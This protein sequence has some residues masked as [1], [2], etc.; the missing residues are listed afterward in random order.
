MG[1]AQAPQLMTVIIIR[2]TPHV[3]ETV[4]AIGPLT[5]VIH[6][7]VLISLHGIYVKIMEVVIGIMIIVMIIMPALVTIIPLKFHVNVLVAVGQIIAV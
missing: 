2:P 5:L 6:I 3:A 1:G 7:H 4:V